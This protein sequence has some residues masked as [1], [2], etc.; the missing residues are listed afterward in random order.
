M[1]PILESIVGVAAVV[2]STAIAV[3]AIGQQVERPP[4]TGR[5]TEPAIA[6]ELIIG[7]DAAMIGAVHVA[8]PRQAR[9]QL[10]VFVDFECAA[11]AAYDSVLT[12]VQEARA[13]DLSLWYVHTPLQG[14][15]FA[16]AA[17]MAF[18]CA[19]RAN[20]AKAFATGLLAQQD[21]IGIMSRPGI[22]GGSIL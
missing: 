2:S 22:P 19:G 7:W 13:S 14:H 16:F 20:R 6:P 1:R 4:S 12:V 18:E 17:A 21:L 3:I 8:G 9:V 11:C 5:S 10:L 15:R